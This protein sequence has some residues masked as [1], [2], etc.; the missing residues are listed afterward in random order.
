MNL[1]ILA[2]RGEDDSLFNE[3]FLFASIIRYFPPTLLAIIFVVHMQRDESVGRGSGDR[4]V[5]QGIDLG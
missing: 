4:S 5:D 1:P 3:P 2:C